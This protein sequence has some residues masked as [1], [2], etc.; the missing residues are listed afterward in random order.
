MPN[1]INRNALDAFRNARL[2]Q[3]L[4]GKKLD[5]AQKLESVDNNVS[6]IGFFDK[7]DGQLVPF[8]KAD[9]APVEDPQRRPQILAPSAEQLQTLRQGPDKLA[10]FLDDSIA[11]LQDYLRPTREALPTPTLYKYNAIVGQRVS[12]FMT[13]ALKIAQDLYGNL[14]QAQLDKALYAVNTR[15]FDLFSRDMQFDSFELNGYASFGHDAAFIHG[16]ELRLK[17]LAKVDER[18]LEP[19]AKQALDREKAQLQ[20]ELDAIFRS[21]YVYNNSS[22]YEVNAEISVGLCLIDKS[23]RQRVSEKLSSL[24]SIVPEYE[25][26]SVRDGGQD[27]AVYYDH[28]TKKHYFDKTDQVVPDNLVA[29]IRRQDV[30]AESLTFRRAESG[31]HL[32]K[33]FRFDW[34]SDGYVSNEK[35][36]WASWAGHCDDKAKLEARGVVLP[37]GDEGVYEY[38]SRSGSTA[39]YDRD[40]LNEKLFSFS[41]MSTEM[42][43]TR[44]GATRS[45]S[46]DQF[47]GARD[48]DRPDLLKLA[49]DTNIPFRG[50]PNKFEIKTIEKDGKTY[51]AS[52]AFREHIVAP[53]G[54]SAVPNPLYKNTSEGDYVNL[55]VGGAKISATAQ[56][57]VFDP[58]SGYPRMER[59]DVAI[60]FANPPAEPIMI[61]SVMQDPGKRQ[62]YEISLDVKN[63]KW[64]AQLIQMDPKQGGGYEKTSVGQPIVR[65]FNPGDLTASRETSLDNPANYY[66][67]V[68][69]ALQLAV[70]F[71]A[72]T[73]DGAGVWNGRIQNLGQVRVWRDD[74]TKWAKVDLNV[75]A[76]YG[77]NSGSF[78]VKLKDDGKPD[79]YVP[80]AL[81]FDFAWR[82]ELRFAP[83]LGSEVNVTARERGVVSQAGNRFTAEAVSNMMEILHCAFNKRRFVINHEGQR[84]FFETR[85]QWEAAKTRL[86]QLRGAVFGN[87]PGPGPVGNGVLLDVPNKAV[88]KGAVDLHE[89]VAQADGTIRISLDTKAGDA[90]LYVN[91]GGP[92]SPEDGKHSHKSWNSDLTKDEI[93]LE[94]VRKGEKIGIAIH[95]YKKSDYGLQVVGPKEGGNVPEPVRINIDAE[96]RVARGEYANLSTYPIVITEA[97]TLELALNAPNGDP[98]LYVG[99]NR[100]PTK[101]AS[102]LQ[103]TST[104]QL[105]TKRLQVKPGDKIYV[106]VYGYA[107]D[108]AFHLNVKTS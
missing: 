96:G 62:M 85:E 29:Q 24:Q 25:L 28:D 11:G 54:K 22:L 66:P 33:N 98:D 43:N 51:Q 90:D 87:E 58:Q 105:E 76:R 52:E 27:K 75:D 92:A 53:D 70:G 65:N 48:D 37:Q 94:G 86:D 7:V 3:E 104:N 13:E 67:F 103:M 49:R 20:G 8:L 6:K 55:A 80:L 36:D 60:D 4:G 19:A 101:S 1:E 83:V 47:A 32:R 12:Q 46:N 44:T 45:L 61:D 91:R 14:G 100:E 42:V 81:P 73:A 35:I 26:L 10:K 40:L 41:E 77:S 79:F 21:K 31:E 93:V 38:D 95:G 84:Y 50:R 59:K 2:D 23:S 78:L 106:R 74:A 72:E 108:N 17:E 56:F 16:W 69:E 82:T 39:H 63:K 68:K 9:P 5:E 15:T 30:A 64:I 88:E 107:P 18:L 34:D 102:D 57:Q 71:T 99:V 97:G 89:I